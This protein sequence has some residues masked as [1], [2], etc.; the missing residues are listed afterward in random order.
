MSLYGLMS[1]LHIALSTPLRTDFL[2]ILNNLFGTPFLV[3]RQA[4][5]MVTGLLRQIGAIPNAMNNNGQHQED[6]HRRM[7]VSPDKTTYSQSRELMENA[8]PMAEQEL[9]QAVMKRSSNKGRSTGSCLG[10]A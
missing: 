3:W 5:R 6:Q 9:G 7:R 8:E 10:N 4:I 2:G 1:A